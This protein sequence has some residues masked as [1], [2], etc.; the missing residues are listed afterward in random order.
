G[1]V[2]RR[3]VWSWLISPRFGGWGGVGAI[4]GVLLSITSA[5]FLFGF[6]GISQYQPFSIAHL[7]YGVA[8]VLLMIFMFQVLRIQVRYR[9][10]LGMLAGMLGVLMGVVIIYQALVRAEMLFSGYIAQFVYHLSWVWILV[11]P[12]FMAFSFSPLFIGLDRQSG[13][14]FILAL[15]AS[16]LT[17]FSGLFVIA[18]GFSLTTMQAFIMNLIASSWILLFSVLLIIRGEYLLQIPQ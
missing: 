15:G 16:I 9:S 11:L 7:A 18:N 4:V 6:P 5:Y 3:R 10:Y 2:T 12:A 8:G 1:L 14:I 17:C 13:A